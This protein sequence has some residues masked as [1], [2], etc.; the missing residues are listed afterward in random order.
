MSQ[1]NLEVS[2]A[3]TSVLVAPPT[4]RPAGT[5]VGGQVVWTFYVLVEDIDTIYTVALQ[6]GPREKSWRSCV[7]A[8][9]R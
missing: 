4:K 5:P 6:K 2:P 1:N 8:L 7:T 3:R 9:R